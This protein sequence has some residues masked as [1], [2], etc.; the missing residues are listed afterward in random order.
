MSSLIQPFQGL[1][2]AART[3]P[4]ARSGAVDAPPAPQAAPSSAGAAPVSLDALPS[5]PPQE[6]LTQIQ[7][8]AGNYEALRA[9]GYEVH[10][11]YD[12]TTRKSTAELRDTSG[13]LI[14]TLSPSEAIALASAGSEGQAST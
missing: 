13:N 3:T 7:T 1:P 5:A 8:A 4:V 12:E 11:A 14:R 10:Y 2:R 9:Q 6:V